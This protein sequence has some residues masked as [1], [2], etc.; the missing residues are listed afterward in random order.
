MS[1]FHLRSG[2][3]ARNAPA[4]EALDLRLVPVAG[5]LWAGALAGLLM[6]PAR[7]AFAGALL[8]VLGVLVVV[9]WR[10]ARTRRALVAVVVVCFAVGAI[11]GAS[12]AAHVRDG[13]VADLAAQEAQVDIDGVV[14]TDPVIRETA[15]AGSDDPGTAGYVLVRIRVD[16][17]SGRGGEYRVRTPVLAVAGGAVWSTLLPGQ[18]VRI[19]GWMSS[20]EG[21]DVAAFVRV[22]GEPE[23]VG[24]PGRIARLT[25]PLRAGLR[26]AVRVVPGAHR[27]LIPGMVVGDESMMG[28]ETREEMRIT[29]LTHLTAVSGT[30]V[31]IVLLAVL[32]VARLIGV[33][34]TALP[35]VGVLSLVGFVLLV[36][37]DPSVLRA[38]VMGTVAV[39]GVVFAGRR[40]ALPALS[41]AVSVL[42]LVDPWLARSVGFALSVS[43]TAGILLL[44]PS[45]ERAMT[46]LPRPLALAVAVPLAAQVA[47]TPV[48]LGVFGQFSIASVPANI[49]V[50]PVVA[51]AMVLGV[52]AT[53]VAPVVPPLAAAIAWLAGWPVWWIAAVARWLA[54]Q[55]GSEY[56]WADGRP[57]ALVGIALAVVGIAVLP[58]VFRRPLVAAG[59]ATV[60]VLVLLRAVPAPGWPPDGWVMVLCDVGQ[61]DGVV[62]RAGPGAGV[63]VDA[64]PDPVMMRRCLDSLR[65][66][67][68]P[69]LVLSHYHADHVDG[70]PG[71]LAGRDVDH[72]LVSP[73]PEPEPNAAQV[74]AWLDAAGVPIHVARAGD[75]W[76]VGE[77]SMEVLWPRRIIRSSEESDPNNASVVLAAE[78]HDVSMLMT[79]DV[80]PLAQRALLRTIPDLTARVLKV[81]HHGSARQEE[82][83]LAGLEAELALIGVGEN[84]HGHPSEEVLGVL[85]RA[86]VEVRRTD[87][88]GTMAVVRLEDESLAVV[89]R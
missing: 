85:E 77:I 88:D 87:Q 24:G 70:V 7:L 46:W 51:P 21:R 82:R 23:L 89:A 6:A 44:V 39:F 56:Q 2:D 48:L 74:A 14:S 54:Y 53:V 20:A 12:R 36:R 63:V 65:I 11:I 38:A 58:V 62:I 81:S 83:F 9:S 67:R 1:A 8:A 13:P 40:R 47:C 45:W 22:H 55:P 57:G 4:G 73:L 29:G 28:A 32:G 33:R 42:V 69:L 31:G 34:G 52:A 72:A 41:T 18:R 3:D 30:H 68:V 5:C 37:P 79:G 61:G 27:G 71:V 64:G 50:A 75:R 35:L 25:E 76:A 15:R 80:E 10:P 26:E 17:I 16:E 60:L 86:G 49:L 43:A 84:S 78:L 66:S 59:T 19:T